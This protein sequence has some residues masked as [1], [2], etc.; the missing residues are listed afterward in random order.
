M[1]RSKSAA[2]L[3]AM[4]RTA[5]SWEAIDSRHTYVNA[6]DLITGA[7]GR[8]VAGQ[9]ARL[10]A[11]FID[12]NAAVLNEVGV[13]ADAV[14]DGSRVRLGFSCSSTIGAVPLRSPVSGRYDHG[15]V[16]HP[17]FQWAGIGA[18]L[19]QMGWRIVPQPLSLSLLP[20]SDRRIPRW[21]IASIV[22]TR[23]ERLLRELTRRFELTS[24]ERSSIRGRVDWSRYA[25]R[26]VGR[27]RLLHVPCTFPDLRDDRYLRAAIRFTV[28]MQRESLAS[29]RAAD[30]MTAALIAK[31]D[32]IEH[33]LADVDS[34][35]P[36][37]R[38]LDAWIR[39]PLRSPTYA[40]GI[41][42]I[43]WTIG[44]RGLAGLS[45]LQGLPWAMPMDQ[46][47]EAWAEAILQ[48]TARHIGGVIRTGRQRQTVTPLVWDPPYTGSQR[49][50]V[51]DIMLDRRDLAV[52][53][54]AKY[55]EH[56]EELDST[57]WRNFGETIRERHR[58]DLLQVLA[59]ANVVTSP[60][61]VVCL[62][63]PCSNE[64]WRS[65]AGRG[66]LFHRASVGGTGRD[67][68][69][70][71]TAFPMGE[72]IDDVARPLIAELRRIEAQ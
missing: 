13:T 70:L 29:Q 36:S 3:I 11:Q 39:G 53:V 60:R 12:Q 27:A 28:R 7:R 9:T 50:L 62:A 15:L 16:V 61:I 17:R 42:A 24:E 68:R 48:T 30:P 51:P 23:I 38:E 21:V 44:E 54:D 69:L 26:N 57:A 40:N 18:M 2:K 19:S 35:R 22:L 34:R 14:F 52:I 10:A 58:A 46:F 63:Y 43:E 49:S 1:A 6:E 8:D 5:R 31:C 45:D 55:K 64:T 71:L 33:S 20:E 41:Q 47:F 65:L 67:L 25:T 56:F 37:P 72:R 4:G 66:S 59:Y 32:T